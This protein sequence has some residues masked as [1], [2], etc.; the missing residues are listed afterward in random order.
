[1]WDRHCNTTPG[2]D[3]NVL[4]EHTRL[5]TCV[6]FGCLNISFRPL[7]H[8]HIYSQH[9]KRRQ[10]GLTGHIVNTATRDEWPEAGSTL[11]RL[12][13]DEKEQQ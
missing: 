6:S 2:P 5:C 8:P 12:C 1:M 10:T 13:G 3:R 11:N 9:S 4:Y 7:K